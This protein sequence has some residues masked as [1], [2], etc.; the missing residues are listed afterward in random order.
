ML[1]E[2]Y[3]DETKARYNMMFTTWWLSYNGKTLDRR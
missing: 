3:W 1:R 2:G